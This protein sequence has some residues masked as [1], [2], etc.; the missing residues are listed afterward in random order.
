MIKLKIVIALLQSAIAQIDCFESTPV[1]VDSVKHL[2][3]ALKKIE[4]VNMLQTVLHQQQPRQNWFKR[5]ISFVA[6]DYRDYRETQR[7]IK[8]ID[9]AARRRGQAE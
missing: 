9:A 6:A 2:Q 7:R 1:N 8:A 4:T 3:I 5:F